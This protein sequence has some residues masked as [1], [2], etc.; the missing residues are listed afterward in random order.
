MYMC[1]F[2]ISAGNSSQLNIEL[3]KQTTKL[4]PVRFVTLF[5][6]Y[7][8]MEKIRSCDSETESSHNFRYKPVPFFYFLTFDRCIVGVGILQTNQ[9]KRSLEAN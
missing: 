7:F 1:D 5:S 4:K 6:N 2:F 9:M 3:A 8:P